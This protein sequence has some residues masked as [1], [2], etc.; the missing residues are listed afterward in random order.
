ML[1]PILIR[2]ILSIQLSNFDL[3]VKTSNVLICNFLRFLTKPQRPD[4]T[5]RVSQ[6]C[7]VLRMIFTSEYH[8]KVRERKSLSAISTP[9]LNTLLCVHLAPINHV[10]YMEPNGEKLS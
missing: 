10:V 5:E 6:F 1:R 4:A 2:W 7:D 8:T 3:E 9:R